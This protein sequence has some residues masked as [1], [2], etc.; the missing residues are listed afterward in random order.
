MVKKGYI[1]LMATDAHNSGSRPPVLTRGLAEL[2]NLVGREQARAMVTHI[3]EKI[4]QGEPV[5]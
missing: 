2:T 1:H 4:I 3:P 5:I